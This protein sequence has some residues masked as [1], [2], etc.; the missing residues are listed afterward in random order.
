MC[1]HLIEV[2]MLKL[3]NRDFYESVICGIVPQIR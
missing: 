2:F 3:H 1:K